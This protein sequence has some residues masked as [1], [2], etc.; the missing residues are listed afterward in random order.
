MRRLPEFW[1]AWLPRRPPPPL[2]L[3]GEREAA[4]FLRRLGYLTIAKG[5]RDRIGELDLVV[6]DGR[7]VVFVEV[8]T[9]RSQDATHPSEAVDADKQRRL[10]RLALN[11]I[12]RHDLLD[13]PVRFDVVAITWPENARRP[14]IEHFKNAFEPPGDWQ[15]FG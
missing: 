12:K 8:K 11:Y 5:H 4:R 14:L 1:R 15:I 9:R 6:V 7:T 10:T 3:R 2:G 13:Y